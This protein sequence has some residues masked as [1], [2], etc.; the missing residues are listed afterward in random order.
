MILKNVRIFKSPVGIEI[1]RQYILK[2]A[3]KSLIISGAPYNKD[4][5]IKSIHIRV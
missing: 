3:N 4:K 1:L 5:A 2:R